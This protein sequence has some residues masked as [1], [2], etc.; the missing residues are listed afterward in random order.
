[1]TPNEY[2]QLVMRTAGGFENERDALLLSGLG[3]AGESG[4]VADHIK[5]VVFHGHDMNSFKLLTEIGDALWYAAFL[6]QVLGSTLEE[7][8][9]INISKLRARYPEGFSH[10][11]SRNRVDETMLNPIVK[12]NRA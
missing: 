5:K 11:R 1:M 7:V 12:G 3:I 9:E 10:E 2:Q 8:M 6:C 4:E